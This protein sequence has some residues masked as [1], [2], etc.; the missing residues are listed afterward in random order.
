M[1]NE[2]REIV[3]ELYRTFS[4]TGRVPQTERVIAAEAEL[5]QML[6]DLMQ[7]V[8][9]NI[10]DDIEQIVSDYGRAYLN[11]GFRGGFGVAKEIFK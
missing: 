9:M 3:E 5:S 6:E 8:P 2:K 7:I 1:E 11:M 10:V 4:D